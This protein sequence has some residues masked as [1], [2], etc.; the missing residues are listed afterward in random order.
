[1]KSIKK[2]KGFKDFTLIEL[3]VVIAIIAI[4]ASMLLPALNQAREKAKSISCASNAKQI[5]MAFMLYT[6]DWDGHYVPFYYKPGH[7]GETKTTWVEQL[8]RQ[9]LKNWNVF[10]C[11]SHVI[12][13][14]MEDQSNSYKEGYPHYGYNYLH[15]GG[16]G[17]GRYVPAFATRPVKTSNLKKASDTVIAADTIRW[18]SDSS[19]GYYTLGDFGV[20]LDDG[21]FGMPYPI[22]SKGFNVVWAD[23]H[24]SKVKTG[25]TDPRSA[26]SATALGTKQNTDSK[27]DRE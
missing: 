24:V 8:Q 18:M 6:N 9:Y 20:V 7:D 13:K 21:R 27:W 26:Y 5:G 3:L 15:V 11:P 19:H 23:G 17:S 1:M 10:Q 4:L 2:S 25:S 12:D 16:T 14:A 22:H